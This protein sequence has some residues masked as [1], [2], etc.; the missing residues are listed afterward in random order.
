MN[1]TGFVSRSY[2][3]VRNRHYTV[4]TG[5]PKHVHASEVHNNHEAD[6]TSNV[7]TFLGF[8]DFKCM[9]DA[10]WR[11]SGDFVGLHKM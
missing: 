1:G 7:G 11:L 3:L 4:Q 9:K 8:L 10:V 6:E 2:D 5:S